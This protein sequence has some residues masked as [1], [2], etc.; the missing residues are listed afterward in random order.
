MSKYGE[1][2]IA[3][4]WLNQSLIFTI[5]ANYSRIPNQGTSMLSVRRLNKQKIRDNF[6]YQKAEGNLEFSK[7][8]RDAN[9]ISVP[10]PK[11]SNE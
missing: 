7:C 1:S 2:P 10:P 4:D 8:K 9:V 5:E 11:K 3:D 6:S